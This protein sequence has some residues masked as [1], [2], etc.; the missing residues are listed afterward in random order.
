M[1]PTVITEEIIAATPTPAKG[2][3]E[4]RDRG[5][6]L[7]IFHTGVHSWSYEYRSPATGKNARIAVPAVT[8]AEARAIAQSYRATVVSGQDPRLERLTVSLEKRKALNAHRREFKRK[9]SM[10]KA[11]RLAQKNGGTV[12]LNPD[13]SFNIT[14]KQA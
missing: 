13:G 1:T 8:L 7:R 12:A 2:Y 9:F 6:T 11:V 4:L 14:F 5:L 3:V 10:L